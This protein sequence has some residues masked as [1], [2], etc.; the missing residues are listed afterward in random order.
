MVVDDMRNALMK[1]IDYHIDEWAQRLTDVGGPGVGGT[2]LRCR[3]PLSSPAETHEQYV[4]L[5]LQTSIPETWEE[6]A[7]CYV[8]GRFSAC[9]VLCAALLEMTLKYELRRRAIPPPRGLGKLIEKAAGHGIMAARLV[10]SAL[11]INVRRNDV[12]HANIHTD[13]P[14]SLLDHTGPEHDVEPMQDLSRNVTKDGWLTGDGEIIEISFGAMGPS[15][16]RVHLFKRAAR[17]S[18]FEAREILEALYPLRTS[19]STQS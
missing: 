7:W 1:S 8:Y 12:V 2:E 18:L 5:S 10:S 11:A 9:I 13:R 16:S 19:P 3:P 4:T 6:A 15:Y 17:A 14:E